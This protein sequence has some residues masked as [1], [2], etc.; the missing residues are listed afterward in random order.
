MVFLVGDCL[1]LGTSRHLELQ[2]IT[3]GSR[4]AFRNRPLYQNLGKVIKYASCC[5]TIM[6]SKYLG[7][8]KSCYHSELHS[9]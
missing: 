1:S 9:C 2:V 3:P 4:G 5:F 6:F 7:K 8:S